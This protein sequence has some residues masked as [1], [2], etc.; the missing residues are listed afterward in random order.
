MKLII[1]DMEYFNLPVEGEHKLILPRS[2]IHHCTGCF[3]C[4]IKTPGRCVIRDGYEGVGMDMGR[5]EE[6]I[7]V[8]R[9][10]Y[11]SLS[12]F[13]KAVQ[14]RALSYIHPDFVIRKG[15]MHHKR[16]Y[17]NVLAL[18]VHLY[19]ENISEAERKTLRGVVEANALNYGGLVKDIH[20]YRS[21]EEMERTV[22]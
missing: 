22:L 1:S 9:C 2:E 19:G 17:G 18:S 3:G 6:L 10:Y 15:E 4:W 12:P 21:A 5:C 20:F 16:R 8:S 13:V 11:G 7:L 14:E